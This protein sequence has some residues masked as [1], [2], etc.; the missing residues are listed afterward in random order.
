VC[1]PWHML[2]APSIQLGSLQAAL[3]AAGLP[4]RSHS[5]HLELQHFLEVQAPELGFSLTDYEEVATGLMNLGVGEWL[6]ALP[7]LRVARNREEDRYTELLLRSG[8]ARKALAKLRRLRARIPDFLRRCADEVLSARPDVVGFTI[9]YS[10]LW[11]S[12]ALAHELKARAPG[13][14]IVFGGASCEGPMGPPLLRLFPALDVVVQGEAEGL[15]PELIRALRDGAEPGTA[16]ARIAGTCWRGPEEVISIPRAHG[17]ALDVE[18]L[19]VPVYDEYFE[20]LAR[21]P[22]G[23]RIL[24]QVPLESSR[25][26]WWGEKNHCTFCGLNGLEM[27][28]RSKSPEKLMAEIDALAARHETLDFLTVD[29][30]LDLDYF[31]SVLPRLAERG[32]DHGF[33]YETKANLTAAQVIAL[34]DAGVRAIQPGI[35]SLSTPVLE[36]MK[37][38]VSALQNARLLKWCARY[39]IRV[40]WNLL[41]GFPR[42][43][44]A[45]YTRMAELVPSLAHFAPPEL[46]RLMVYRFSPY[47]EAPERHGLRL[48]GP[49]PY[50]ALLHDT[51]DATRTAMAQAFEYEHLDGRDPEGY[52]G[53]LRE[54]VEH[55]RRDAER[56]RDALTYRRG[57]GFLVITD[58]RTTT[59][60]SAVRY[61]LGARESRVYLACEAGATRRSLGDA[62]PSD[63]GL[64][65]AELDRL[66][67]DLVAARLVAELDGRFLALAQPRFTETGDPW[68]ARGPRAR[69]S[70]SMTE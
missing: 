16:A 38:G 46:V 37:K 47:H 31:E 5:F 56:N 21:S 63:V 52:V 12:A 32:H 15:L 66:L 51:D 61:T 62:G 2:A 6:F 58:T 7:P 50:Y 24:P 69:R 44:P 68:L 11:P 3:D 10:Q 29:N 42:E 67:A 36:H 60:R 43:D 20:R 8:V 59:T 39:G 18:A 54:A 13:L 48:K 19:P 45:E 41:Y 23:H 53:A 17:K 49:L 35:E 34:R 65:T 40:I 22:L 57:P 9:V 28:F 25:G 1:M 33:F 4:A 14:K 55:W 26:C 70:G 27:R 30:I 64:S